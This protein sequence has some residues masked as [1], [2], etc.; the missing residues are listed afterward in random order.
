MLK[1]KPQ[2]KVLR[3][4]G[5]RRK[6]P[7]STGEHKKRASN[8]Y[9]GKPAARFEE[10]RRRQRDSVDHSLLLPTDETSAADWL[11]ARGWISSPEECQE[12]A[13]RIFCGPKI[14]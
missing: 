14:H 9:K 3:Q 1:G 4:E 6:V 13:S 12:C 11:L 5:K 2:R 10:V 8:S 7:L